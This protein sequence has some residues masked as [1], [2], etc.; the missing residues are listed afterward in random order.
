MTRTASA[1]GD[2]W[3]RGGAMHLYSMAIQTG[4]NAAGALGINSNN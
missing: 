4:V 1:L 2:M 3:R